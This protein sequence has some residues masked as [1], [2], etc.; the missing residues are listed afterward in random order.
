MASPFL[1]GA[2]SRH[3]EFVGEFAAFPLSKFEFS[4][5]W[6]K[7]GGPVGP[8]PPKERDGLEEL[9]IPGALSVIGRLAETAVAETLPGCHSRE[10]TGQEPGRC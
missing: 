10:S 3:S 7:G 4:F 6:Q 9:N 5:C 2:G 8:M 1:L